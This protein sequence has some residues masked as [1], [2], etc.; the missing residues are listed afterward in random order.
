M[1]GISPNKTGAKPMT[2]IYK[3]KRFSSFKALYDFCAAQAN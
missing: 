1:L 3:Q 2:I